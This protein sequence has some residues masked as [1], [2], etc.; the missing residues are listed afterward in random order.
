MGE[1][2][3]YI[4]IYSEFLPCQLRDTSLSHFQLL[5]ELY[6]LAH[7]E[8]SLHCPRNFAKQKQAEV[9]DS[10]LEEKGFGESTPIWKRSR[11]IS[12]QI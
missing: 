7:L 10:H 6:D 1:Q 3:L 8:N 2:I 4:D 11:N 12:R 9:R 5:K